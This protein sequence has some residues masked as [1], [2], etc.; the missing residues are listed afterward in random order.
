MGKWAY[1]LINDSKEDADY[2][3]KGSSAC[4]PLTRKMSKTSHSNKTGVEVMG[5]LKVSSSCPGFASSAQIAMCPC[6]APLG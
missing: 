2:R 5:N 3:F 1:E 6:R 4:F